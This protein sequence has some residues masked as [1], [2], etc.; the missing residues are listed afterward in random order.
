M[1][2]LV[3][4]QWTHKNKKLADEQLLEIQNQYLKKYGLRPRKRIYREIILNILDDTSTRSEQ[5]KPQHISLRDGG[6][7]G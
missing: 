3:M 4:T 2:V 6:M 7:Y 5:Q 1:G